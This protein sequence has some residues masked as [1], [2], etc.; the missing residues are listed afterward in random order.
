MTTWTRRPADEALNV[1]LA[2]VLV[3]LLVAGSLAE[4]VIRQEPQL[5]EVFGPDYDAY[6][7][8][9]PLFIPWGVLF[10]SRRYQGPTAD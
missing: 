4:K 8:Q 3:P 10:P 7:K 9:V 6:R 5:V 2:F 1:L